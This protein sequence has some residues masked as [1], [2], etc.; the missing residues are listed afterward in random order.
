MMVC[1][2][3]GEVI[4]E[5]EVMCPVCGYCVRCEVEDKAEWYTFLRVYAKRW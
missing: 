4:H 1:P 5:D 3:C 2:I